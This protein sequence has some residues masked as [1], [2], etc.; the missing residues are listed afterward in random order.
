MLISTD[1]DVVADRRFIKLKKRTE[2][3]ERFVNKRFDDL[4]SHS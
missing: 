1:S 2:K 3:Y 4:V